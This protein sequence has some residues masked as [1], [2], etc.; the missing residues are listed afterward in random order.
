MGTAINKQHTFFLNRLAC[1]NFSHC[2]A[3]AYVGSEC[4][5][6]VKCGFDEYKKTC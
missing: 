4:S 3:I 2:I 1:Y 6:F 5:N